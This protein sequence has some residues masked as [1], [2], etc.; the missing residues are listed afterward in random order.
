MGQICES[1]PSADF[2]EIPS[3]IRMN[4]PTQ[5]NSIHVHD[6]KIHGIFSDGQEYLGH[7][8]SYHCR[9]SM[10]KLKQITLLKHNLRVVVLW[11]TFNKEKIYKTIIVWKSHNA[12]LSKRVIQKVLL[13]KYTTQ[14]FS[15]GHNIMRGFLSA[16]K[17]KRRFRRKLVGDE[18]TA[19]GKCDL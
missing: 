14:P 11:R 8:T 2:C 6:C 13:L 15:I 10:R 16:H 18:R 4:R 5:A 1:S 17:S 12:S 3:D 19:N 7:P 9:F